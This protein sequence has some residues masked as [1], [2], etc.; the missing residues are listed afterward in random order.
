M[1]DGLNN[2]NGQILEAIVQGHIASGTVSGRQRPSHS[3]TTV[4]NVMTRLISGGDDK[5]YLR[6]EKDTK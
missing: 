6:Q 3:P 4:R 2:R 5:S 1:A